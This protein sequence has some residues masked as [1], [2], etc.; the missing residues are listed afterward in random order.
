VALFH[1]AIGC[2]E[3]LETPL[4]DAARPPPPPPRPRSLEHDEQEVRRMLAG[5]GG[6]TVPAQDL[7]RGDMP[8][9]ELPAGEWLR[10]E[11][12][13]ESP[14]WFARPGLPATTVRRLKR[15]QL[16]PGLTL[17][18]HGLTASE[19]RRQVGN[20]ITTARQQD[21]RVVRLIHGKAAGR[22]RPDRDLFSPLANGPV[23][24]AMLA[25]WLPG[26]DPVLALAS[27]PPEQ[28]GRGAVIVL[29]RRGYRDE[30]QP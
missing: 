12:T 28:G 14:L 24:K 20:L 22:A 19:A 21:V 23:L 15:G 3:R 4:A 30:R 25:E 10:D 2:V 29:L 1:E 27:A 18:L 9:A 17:D 16:E 8:G 7:R 11:V 13:P 5:G 6:L 26:L